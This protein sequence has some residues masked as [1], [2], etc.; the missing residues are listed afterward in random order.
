[1]IE[2]DDGNAVV[3]HLK[4]GD[5]AFIPE[6]VFHSTVNT[7]WEP[8]PNPGDLLARRPGGLPAQPARLHDRPGRRPP[9]SMRH[10]R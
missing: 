7:T 1:M 2:D 3:R 4:P 6:G 8:L 10:T 9:A 5:M